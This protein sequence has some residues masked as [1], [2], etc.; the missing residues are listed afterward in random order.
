M[1]F[2]KTRFGE[3]GRATHDGRGKSRMKTAD[4]YGQSQCTALV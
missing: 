2:V 1:S 3:Q 4:I